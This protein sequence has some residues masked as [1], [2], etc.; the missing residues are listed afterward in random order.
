MLSI[1]PSS[2]EES[3]SCYYCSW[4]LNFFTKSLVSDL[5]HWLSVI[6]L[7]NKSGFVFLLQKLLAL[8]FHCSFLKQLPPTPSSHTQWALTFSTFFVLCPHV[9]LKWL[10][11]AGRRTSYVLCQWQWPSNFKN[12]FEREIISIGTNDSSVN[13]VSMK[14]FHALTYKS[15]H[16]AK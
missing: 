10:M 15:F 9:P 8:L 14:P 7:H 16:V 11:E 4:V 2:S 13:M 6:E 1:L 3:L 12:D 5:T